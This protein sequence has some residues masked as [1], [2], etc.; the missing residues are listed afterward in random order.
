MKFIAWFFLIAL[1]FAGPTVWLFNFSSNLTLASERVKEA[2]YRANLSSLRTIE[3]AQEKGFGPLP[4][5]G[6]AELLF[7]GDVMLGRGVAYQAKRH[8]GYTYPF[9]EVVDLLGSADL[10]FGNL[11]GPISSRGKNQGSEYSFRFEPSAAKALKATGFDVVSLANNH[12]LDYGV[13]ALSDTMRYLK[14][15]GIEAVGAGLNYNGANQ[16]KIL[17]VEGIKL[18]F[19]AYTN[20]YPKS[21][22]AGESEAGV[23]DFDLEKVKESILGV[24]DLVDLVIVSWH[25]G[26]EYK[27]KASDLQGKIAKEMVDAGADLV[28]GHHPHVP[29][30]VEQYKG[31]WI[32]Y[33]L[34]NFVF[35][36][37]FSKETMGGLLIKARVGGP[38]KKVIQIEPLYFKINETFQPYFLDAVTED[39]EGEL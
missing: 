3:L 4:K 31:A 8:G 37:N 29:Q 5:V 34:G 12:I 2:A 19:L 20:L 32:F 24:R 16:P 15:A 13:E 22:V 26:E 33:S 6:E 30:E 10:V 25:W 1:V 27:T 28:V 38:E 9:L 23:S 18:A 36:Q 35:D 17:E 7:V 39:G 14:E 11:E 21:L